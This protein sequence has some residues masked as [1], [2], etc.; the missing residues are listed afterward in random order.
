MRSGFPSSVVKLVDRLNAQSRLSL[1]GA[2]LHVLDCNMPNT[3]PL[4]I[5]AQFL[6]SDGR[7]L[8]GPRGNISLS[9]SLCAEARQPGQVETNDTVEFTGRAARQA[10]CPRHGVR[11][12]NGRGQHQTWRLERSRSNFP[13]HVV[14]RRRA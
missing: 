12:S 11:L 5:F 13:I 1:S 3:E 14:D 7:R 10:G 4:L 2:F 8:L 9:L 6:L